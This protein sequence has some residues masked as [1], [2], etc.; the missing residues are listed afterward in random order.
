M[1][2]FFLCI[3]LIIASVTSCLAQTYIR[4][5]DPG[6]IGNTFLIDCDNAT[7][8][9]STNVFL[10][11]SGLDENYSENE[12]YIRE[13]SSTNGGDINLKFTQFSLANGTVMTIRDAITHEIFASYATGTQLVGQTFTSHRGSLQIIWSS[14]TAVRLGFCAAV[15][16]GSM[17]QQFQTTITPSI[18]PIVEGTNTYYDVCSGT[19]INF[20]ATSEFYQ[21]NVQYAQYE[22]SLT[23]DWG[24]ID[25]NNDTLWFYDAGR[26]F[27]HTFT[28][29]GAFSVFCN[30]SDTHGCLNNNF[31]ML[32]VRVSIP[33]TWS[34]VSFYPDS[35][36]SGAQITL[37]GEPR[38]ETWY[39]PMNYNLNTDTLFLPD[40]TNICYN[41]IVNFNIFNE[42]ATITSMDDIDRIYLNMEHSFLGDL[43]IMIECP[44]GQKCLLKAYENGTMPFLNW[45]NTGGINNIESGGGHTIHLGLAPDPMNGGSADTYSS[46]YTIAGEGYSYNFTPTAN[47]P[48]GPNGPTTTI[49]YTDP[50]GNTEDVRILNEGDYAS[51]ESMA[52]LVGCPLNG[53]WTIYLCDHLALDNGYLFEWGIYFSEDVYHNNMWSYSNSYPESSFSWSGEG[54]QTGMNGDS[55]A[56]AIVHNSDTTNW[57]EFPY[58]FTATDN[59]GCSYDT[60]IIVHVKPAMHEDCDS[61]TSM[62]NANLPDEIT[63]LPN[64]AY[65]ILNIT[66][67]EQISEIE[68]VNALGQVVKRLEVNADNVVCNVED[69]ISGV[70]VVRIRT[71]QQTHID[72]LRGTAISQRKFV[73]E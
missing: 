59:F 73:K 49:S 2:H 5:S 16:C 23:Y 17:C 36:C 21:N 14:G 52:S 56:T 38:P 9:F 66:S 63:I 50:C 28:E 1:R 10:L 42:G 11:D 51:Y 25:T 45:T 67:S 68:I 55:Y 37:I 48:F 26:N 61:T 31:N 64:P 46:C 15:W 43:S 65:D 71:L 22:D 47:N 12:S 53:L 39:S 13:I 58:T 27:S 24:V 33:P 7:S 44:N 57:R 54:L 60:T 72:M 70:Y 18:N 32:R 3:V 20:S 69:L 30:A 29:N 8:P 34:A 35:V 41:A 40:G 4:I 62:D 19:E 6:D